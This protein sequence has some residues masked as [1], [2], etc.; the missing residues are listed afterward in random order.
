MVCL[1]V[2]SLLL[3]SMTEAG[4]IISLA[5]IGFVVFL[6]IKGNE[7]TAKNY[8]AK[9]WEIINTDSDTLTVLRKRWK[10]S[11]VQNNLY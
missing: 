9:G 3:D 4:I 2:L 10:I 6:A 11:A 1:W 7:L 5:I 8:L